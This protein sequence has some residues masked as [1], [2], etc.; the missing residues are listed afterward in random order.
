MEDTMK[1]G[2]GS[3]HHFRDP[4][5]ILWRY[6]KWIPPTHLLQRFKFPI[7]LLQA[8]PENLSINSN[9]ASLALQLRM[10]CKACEEQFPSQYWLPY[11]VSHEISESIFAQLL[12]H[13][14]MTN[15]GSECVF[16]HVSTPRN[17]MHQIPTYLG[18]RANMDCKKQLYHPF[19]S[20]NDT[21]Q[22]WENYQLQMFIV[23]M[24]KIASYWNK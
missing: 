22:Q 21:A 5:A 15:E 1:T 2:C 24:N 8:C 11:R 10:G 18:S 17:T 12:W 9:C 23:Q 13:K 20:P 19:S 6:V 3:A 16:S 14:S 7:L 4:L